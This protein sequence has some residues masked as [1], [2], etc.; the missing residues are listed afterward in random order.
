M[1]IL[2]AL[3]YFFVKPAR[4]AILFWGPK[5]INAKLGSGM[6]ESPRGSGEV[7]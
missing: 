1:V 3:V 4:Y 7:A 6:G 2:L 5:Y